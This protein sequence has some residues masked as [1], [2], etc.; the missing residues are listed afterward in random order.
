LLDKI[1]KEENDKNVRE[2]KLNNIADIAMLP[3]QLH[4]AAPARHLSCA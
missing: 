2:G 4:L 3:H 1:L